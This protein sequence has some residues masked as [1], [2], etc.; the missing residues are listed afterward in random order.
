VAGRAPTVSAFAS[1]GSTP[2]C[3]HTACMPCALALNLCSESPTILVSIACAD[4]GIARRRQSRREEGK[5]W[6][7]R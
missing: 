1:M 3:A 2:Y 5:G 4:G 6:L 7:G